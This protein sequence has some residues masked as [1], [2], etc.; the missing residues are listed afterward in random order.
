M[1]VTPRS[2]IRSQDE[3]E[4]ER[5]RTVELILESVAER[6]GIDMPLVRT[7]GAAVGVRRVEF[8]VLDDERI[9]LDDGDSEIS[10]F[11]RAPVADTGIGVLD[12]RRDTRMRID[13]RSVQLRYEARILHLERKGIVP[14]SVE[15][16]RVPEVSGV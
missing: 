15:S 12:M 16:V 2:G 9:W 6:I 14:M 7:S 13:D 11:D 4:A 8:A 10:V 1:R 3:P 5:R